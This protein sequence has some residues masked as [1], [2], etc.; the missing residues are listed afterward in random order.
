[1]SKEKDLNVGLR[2]AVSLECGGPFPNRHD[3]GKRIGTAVKNISL[4][5]AP[6]FNTNK[7]NYKRSYIL[8][9]EE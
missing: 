7:N 5:F 9:L 3:N 6:D 4:S 8:P 2:M 1:M